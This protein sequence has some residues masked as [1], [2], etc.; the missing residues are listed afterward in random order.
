MLDAARSPKLLAGR[1]LRKRYDMSSAA[2]PAEKWNN[3][4]DL[5]KRG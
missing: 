5:R 1:L 2:Q 4:M 3:L